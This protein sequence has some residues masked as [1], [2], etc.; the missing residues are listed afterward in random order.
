MRTIK[1][2]DAFSKDVYSKAFT[3]FPNSIAVLTAFGLGNKIHRE[4]NEPKNTP[5]QL[6]IQKMTFDGGGIFSS[7][8]QCC[9]DDED[10]E[11]GFDP[12]YTYV[13]DVTQCGV[14]N[15][16]ACQ[17]LGAIMLP[18]TYRVRLND[19]GGLGYVFLSLTRYRQDE[20]GSVPRKIIF[21][22]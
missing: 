22:E 2:F 6:I 4:P 3:V 7:G 1:L 5:Q 9:C 10:L 16:N 14:W 11:L 21:G 17:N 18:G 12:N 20:A 19:E 8:D 15:L 13:E